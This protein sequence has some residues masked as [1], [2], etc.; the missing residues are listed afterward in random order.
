M[1]GAVVGLIGTAVGAV[2][3]VLG[4]L[5]TTRLGGKE[6]RRTQRGQFEREGRSIAYSNLV[7]ECSRTYRVG[8]AAH[9]KVQVPGVQRSPHLAD[10]L[11]GFRP[12]VDAVFEAVSLV[13]LH[14]PDGV[15]HAANN[16]ASAMTSWFREV[17]HLYDGEGDAQRASE[18]IELYEE[19]EERF[20]TLG[21]E[22]LLGESVS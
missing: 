16:L 19:L 13:R 18:A 11:T 9:V 6:Q 4:T 10:G 5:A 7:T 8:Y 21:R 14:G 17:Q 20:I 3:G 1:D 22:A 2:S 12:A 15:A